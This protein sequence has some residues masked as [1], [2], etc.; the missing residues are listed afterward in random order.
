MTH[1]KQSGL[2]SIIV[3]M[4]TSILLMVVSTGFIRI[5]V[6]E[7]SRASNNNL[8]RTAY[9]S[10][11]A[12]VEDGKRAI[13]A[14]Q[15]GGSASAACKAIAA[16][17]CSTIQDAGIISS[18]SNT[19][20]TIKSG[21]NLQYISGQAYTCVLI[22][23]QTSDVVYSLK[24]GSSRVVPLRVNKDTSIIRLQWMM[25]NDKVSTISSADGGDTL[26]KRVEWPADAPALLRIQ[27]VV[28]EST[29]VNGQQSFDSS[30]VSTAFLRP[31]GIRAPRNLLDSTAFNAVAPQAVRAAGGATNATAGVSPITCSAEAFDNHQYACSAYV[32]LPRNLVAG[33]AMAFLRITSIYNDTDIRLSFDN[34]GDGT[35]KFDG[36]QP[37][38]DS[39]GRAGDVYRRVSSRI[40]SSSNINYPEYAV[41]ITGS[42]CKDFSVTNQGVPSALTCK[43]IPEE[44]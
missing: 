5:M 37:K 16:K 31:S 39:T 9:E 32:A 11:V 10:A 30:I 6:Q 29:T 23:S 27:A 2:V 25:K 20:I 34:I 18:I 7:E 12:G 14:C 3:V 4:F 17:R 13:M 35:I 1:S 38:V 21:T 41:D 26:P 24:E 42:L 44:Q 33:N 15:R 22:D 36:V 40:S 28:P 19:A 8:S 43:V